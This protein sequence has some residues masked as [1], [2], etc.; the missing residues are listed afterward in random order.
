MC[1]FTNTKLGALEQVLFVSLA[2][3]HGH[4]RCVG[5]RRAATQGLH[6]EDAAA[7]GKSQI[8]FVNASLDSTLRSAEERLCFA[9][10]EDQQ[11]HVTTILPF[12][13]LE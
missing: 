5:V 12:R 3:Q 2:L 11:G 1:L 6:C 4:R 7:Q 13:N 10:V 9:L 8:T